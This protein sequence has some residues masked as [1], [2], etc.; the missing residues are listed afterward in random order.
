M[1]SILLV[2]SQINGVYFINH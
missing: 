1:L 2:S